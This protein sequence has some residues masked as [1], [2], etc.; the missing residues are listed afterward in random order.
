MGRMKY[1]QEGGIS[2]R[3]MCL[4]LQGSCL[5]QVSI[6]LLTSPVSSP[7]R[8]AVLKSCFGLGTSL[9]RVNVSLSPQ[10]RT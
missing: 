1:V 10:G 8:Q 9:S 6:F 4:N 7:T 5:L 3:D 2:L